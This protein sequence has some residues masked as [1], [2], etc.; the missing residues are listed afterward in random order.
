MYGRFEQSLDRHITGNWGEDHPAV[1]AENQF[2]ALAKEI[3]K[4]TL[5]FLEAVIKLIKQYD[6]SD[7]DCLFE[8][9]PG[10]VPHKEYIEEKL[11][12]KIDG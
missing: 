8:E 7:L 10:L 1:I 9:F 3:E 4:E 11:K 12:V 2:E 6:V 5:K